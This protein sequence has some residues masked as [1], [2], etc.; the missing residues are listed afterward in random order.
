VKC[1]VCL[2]PMRPD[3]ERDRESGMTYEALS[4][5]YPFTRRQMG[6]HL[7]NHYT[8]PKPEASPAE[9]TNRL[10]SLLSRAEEL[11]SSAEGCS[12]GEKTKALSTLNQV[13]RLSLQV[14]GQLKS[15]APAVQNV[16]DIRQ[17]MEYRL[18][19]A[20]INEACVCTDCRKNLLEVFR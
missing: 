18:L 19:I 2:S 5:K 17:S 14:S 20:K 13:M 12:I 16:S 9:L 7:R 3:I 15:L 8:P 1:A 10:D 6:T 4:Q 11:V